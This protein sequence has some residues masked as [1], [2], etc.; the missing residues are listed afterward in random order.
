MATQ[1][2]KQA[3]RPAKP[4]GRYWRGKAP[5]GAEDLP[6]SDEEEEQEEAPE[7]EGDVPLGGEQQF[8]G[9]SAAE[10]EDEGAQARGKTQASKATRMNIALRDVNISKE[11]RVI[12]AGRDE[13]GR[14]EREDGM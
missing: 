5:K 1:V 13:V 4:V 7:E 8:L 6:S 9:D 11:G 14:T 3:P 10:D 2:R 12:V